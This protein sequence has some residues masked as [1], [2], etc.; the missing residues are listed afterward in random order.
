MTY[1]PGQQVLVRG[2]IKAPA[3]M[4]TTPGYWV[5]HRGGTTFVAAADVVGPAPATPDEGG[6]TESWLRGL[7][8]DCVEV[9]DRLRETFKKVAI[10]RDEARAAL[11]AAEA[12]IVAALKQHTRDNYPPL[13]DFCIECTHEP[14]LFVP[15]PCPTVRALSVE[16]AGTEGG[17]GHE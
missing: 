13:G 16:A 9:R 11:A 8:A 12:R 4:G 5:I 6:D 1:E 17:G 15:W 3:I 7:L 14:Q 10:E 2:E